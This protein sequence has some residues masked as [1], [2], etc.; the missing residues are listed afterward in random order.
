MQCPCG[1]GLKYKRCCGN[2]NQAAAGQ[3]IPS[4][5]LAAREAIRKINEQKIVAET[6]RKKQQGLGKPII[7]AQL[8]GTQFIAVGSR[9]HYS[10][11]WKTFPDF[12]FDFMIGKLG[13]DWGRAE[14]PKPLM[15]R[16]PI[17]Q[18]YDHVTKLQ[19]KFLE[20]PGKITSLNMT[21]GMYC[22]YGLAYSLYLL[23]HNVELQEIYIKRL[24]DINNFQGAYYELMVA[25]CLIRAGFALA[26]EDETDESKKHCEFYATSVLTG[27]KYWV[28]AKARSV[29]GVLGKNETNGT[30]STDPTSQLTDHLRKAFLK[31]T[32]D[33]RLVFVDVN[34]APEVVSR[35][36]WAERAGGKL[37]QKERDLKNGQAAYVFVTNMCFHWDLTSESLSPTLLVHGLGIPDFAKVGRFRLSEI[38]WQRKKHIDAHSIA[39][40]FLSYGKLPTTLDGRM[41]SEAFSELPH[42]IKIGETYYFDEI[43]T[44]AKVTTATVM[45]KNKKMYIGTDK[46]QILEMPMSEEQLA[47]YRNHKDVY[48][49]KKINVGKQTNNTYDFFEELVKIHL[50]HPRETI[51]KK[52][53]VYSDFE[54]LSKLT[55]EELV[56]EYCE[57][58]SA[59]LSQT[60]R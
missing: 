8:N 32:S 4:N 57:R 60:S 34:S 55:H 20:A 35:P 10:R 17:M 16:H 12:L 5:L 43:D 33:E 44:L 45:E 48:F 36:T 22:Y 53:G 29:V 13:S 11:D 54:Q 42:S 21:G 9:L 31:P 27:K 41:P 50:E 59:N 37:D 3:E 46:G 2:Q 18:W 52:F 28:E 14:M 58:L 30:K 39:E 38:Y 1:S 19:K 25:N 56:V 51:L 7:S 23:N 49:G 40:A 6:I 47:D 15:E 24:K 26:L